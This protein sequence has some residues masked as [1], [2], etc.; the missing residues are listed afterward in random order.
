MIICKCI[1]SD[2][3]RVA[4][5]IELIAVPRVGDFIARKHLAGEFEVKK[6]LFEDGLDHVYVV[7]K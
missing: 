1:Y 5:W 7:V 3:S 2:D 4:F 6:V